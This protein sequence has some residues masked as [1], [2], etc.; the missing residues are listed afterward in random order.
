VPG[1]R[2]AGSGRGAGAP[3][4]WPLR[5][6]A[7]LAAGC[8]AGC[9]LQ[10][11]SSFGPD[12]RVVELED[13]PFY[14]QERYQCGP[15][16]LMTLLDYS[17]VDTTVEALVDAVYLPAREGS[18][19][20]ELLA[21][22]R[23]AGRL[24]YRIDG[25]LDAIAEELASGR[26]VLVLQ[27][28]GVSWWPR[29]H[30]AVVYRTDPRDDSVWLRSGTDP[31]RRTPA[32]TFMNTWRRSD[33]WAIV[34]LVPGSLPANPDS[35]RYFSA[36][37]ALEETGHAAEARAAWQAAVGEWPESAVPLFG[38]ANAELALG[39]YAAAEAAYRRLLENWPSQ[40]MARN[41][42]AIA[43]ARQGRIGEG[44]AML[45]EA[46]EDPGLEPALVTLMEGT[47]KEINSRTIE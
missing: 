11:G 23:A 12:A 36:V 34:A 45:E 13:T 25:T 15:A 27:N 20:S 21:A 4:R 31:A 17:G 37:A 19:Q 10:P 40:A 32:A 43:L 39:R 29:W 28:L 2:A 8:L 14:P 22:T 26:P 41:N 18:L 30:Y 5:C 44:A 6:I 33:H 3:G 1:Q 24:P 47:L 16:A 38:L 42:L 46:L 7:W 9:A 35:G